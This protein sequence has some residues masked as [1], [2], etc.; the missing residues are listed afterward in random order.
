MENPLRK[1]SLRMSD[2]ERLAR[3]RQQT[4]RHVLTAIVVVCGCILATINPSS[5][6]AIV[7]MV[8]VMGGGLLAAR[9]RDR[10]R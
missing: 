9:F 7:S 3:V 6:T 4:F 2:V 10:L 8:S 1:R 5:S